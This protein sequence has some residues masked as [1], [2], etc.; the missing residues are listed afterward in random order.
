MEGNQRGM[1]IASSALVAAGLLFLG[2]T[3]FMGGVIDFTLP[4]IFLTLGPGFVVL[5]FSLSPRWRYAPLLR[6]IAQGL[7]NQ[8]IADRLTLASSTVKTHINNICSKLDV[9]TRVQAVNKA[10][11]LGYS[12]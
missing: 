10:R 2:L 11:G 12:L 5:V 7:S 6:L 1:T 9:Q 8:Q 3:I 4:L